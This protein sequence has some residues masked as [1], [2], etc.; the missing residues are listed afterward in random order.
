[1]TIAPQERN[2]LLRLA[3]ESIEIGLERGRLSPLPATVL[4]SLSIERATFVTLRVGAALR[5]CCGSIEPR[6]TLAEDVW[7]N[8]WASAFADPRFPA[9]TRDEYFGLR[10]HVSVLAP[11]VRLFVAGEDELIASLRPGIDGVVLQLGASRA[12]FLP[13]VWETIADP[14]DFIA[15]LKAK[16]GWSRTFWSPQIHIWKYETES[17]GEE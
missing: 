1:M 2:E 14:R 16:A 9:L 17:F 12:T 6:F 7:R 8:A 4:P 11:L 5:G 13:S 3:R 10:V 15:H